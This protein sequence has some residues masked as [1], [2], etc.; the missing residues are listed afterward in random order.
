MA[1]RF[2]PDKQSDIWVMLRIVP[3]I[4]GEMKVLRMENM[5][6]VKKP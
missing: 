3:A 4:Q 1:V 6:G 2:V 5:C